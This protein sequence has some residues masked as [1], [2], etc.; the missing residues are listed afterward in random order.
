MDDL[1]RRPW[2]LRMWTVQEL[3]MAN[4][5]VVV[6]G[7]KVI[8]WNNLHWGIVGAMDISNN[9]NS[10]TFSDALTSVLAAESLWLDLYV[11]NRWAE[12]G[13]DW[14][15][16]HTGARAFAA[17]KSF[18]EFIERY[19]RR[20]YVGQMVSI[21][22]IILL[23]LLLDLPPFDSV[24]LLFLILA[25]LATMILKLH[26]G[27]MDWETNART[28]LVGMLNM[29]RVRDATNPRDKVF[30]LYGVLK[31][32]EIIND[33]SFVDYDQSI[34]EAYLRFTRRMID[35]HQKLEI[36]VEASEPGLP[37]APSWVPDWSRR[38][39]RICR[40]AFEAT[41]GS[42]SSFSFSTCWRKLP[43]VGVVVD[44]ITFC[45]DTLH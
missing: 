1:L 27:R 20:I 4:Q 13:P 32:L 43:I 3:V 41:P 14:W 19:G 44:T 30:A 12:S 9:R 34:G 35:W 33:E 26:P 6:C 45:T 25:C 31:E 38:Q 16:R 22:T 11:K 7:D 15:L 18:F 37:N 24:G 5:P 36:L 10:G 40:G 39:Y 28:K 17:R 8:R 2:F 42:A 29:I 21:L 23:R